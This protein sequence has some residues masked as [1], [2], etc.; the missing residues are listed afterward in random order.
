M[1][2]PYEAALARLQE[3]IDSFGAS[4]YGPRQ[5]LSEAV[6]VS[7]RERRDYW[8]GVM[9]RMRR[10]QERE[11]RRQAPRRCWS[12]NPALVDPNAPSM[13]RFDR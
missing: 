9:S 3:R 5:E 1:A 11:A 12:S 6:R 4:L 10:R 7:L 13:R 2:L 8:H